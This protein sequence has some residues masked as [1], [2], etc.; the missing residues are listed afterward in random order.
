VV[1]WLFAGLFVADVLGMFHLSGGYYYPREENHPIRCAI[2]QKQ[3]AII[4][5]TTISGEIIT[6]WRVCEE[7]YHT[8]PYNLYFDP[9][10]VYRE[11]AEEK[12]P[13]I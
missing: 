9:F 4:K 5:H 2:C 13:V 11:K 12:A 7:C 10:G 1:F 3:P 8:I 6:T